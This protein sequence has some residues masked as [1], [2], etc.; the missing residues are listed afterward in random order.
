LFAALLVFPGHFELVLGVL[1]AAVG[2]GRLV[3]GQLESHENDALPPAS[4][5]FRALADPTRPL[6]ADDPLTLAPRSGDPPDREG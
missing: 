2:A 1:I 6:A 3:I 5:K 4:S